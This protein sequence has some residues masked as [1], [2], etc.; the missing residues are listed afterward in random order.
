MT[1]PLLLNTLPAARLLLVDDEENILLSLKRLLKP[2]GYEIFTAAN[3]AEALKLLASLPPMDM[4]ISDM[5][6]P[7]MDGAELLEQVAI[8]WPDTMRILLTG[9]ADLNSAISAINKAGIYRYISK[10]WDDS[11]FKLTLQRALERKRLEEVKRHLEEFIQ[12]QNEDLKQLNENLEERVVA[13]TNELHQTMG[14]L[15]QAYESLKRQYRE[16]IKVF[17]TL[18][19]MREGTVAGHSR[20][21]ADLARKVAQRLGLSDDDAQQILYAGLLHDIGKMCLPDNLIN[22]PFESLPA[23]DRDKVT[24]H[25]MLGQA[26]LMALEPLRKAAALIRS[27]HEYYDGSGYPEGISGEDIPLG[28][29]I[30]AVVSD[31]DA[32]QLGTLTE[33][34]LSAPEAQKVI[35]ENSGK[36]YDPKVVNNFLDVINESERIT[37]QKQSIIK[38]SE[39]RAGMVLARD[40]ITHEG[41]LL[42]S[43][44][45]MLDEQLIHTVRY[46]EEGLNCKLDIHV[47]P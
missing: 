38:A 20:R 4:I 33:L 42:L 40:L 15:E 47:R 3:G 12:K 29:R 37:G 23:S 22:K 10:P 32:L 17:A 2:L 44:D 18:M 36:L 34:R 26:V 6:M 43:K 28:A 14:F 24:R 31:Y 21:V 7:Y 11:D 1:E 45:Y 41:V 19:E 46:I 16:S 25:P 27:H 8:K 30:L 5:R 35:F 13:R 9:Y 39:L